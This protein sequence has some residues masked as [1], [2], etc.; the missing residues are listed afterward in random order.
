MATYGYIRTSRA[1]E[2][3]QPGSDPEA[4]R[5][6]LIGAGV[7]ARHI[8]A[9]V[10]VSGIAGVSSRNG[11]RALDSRLD[12][13][14]VLTVVA[15]DR[16]GR[17]YLDVMHAIHTLHSR[18]VRLRTLAEEEAT[19]AAFLDADPDSPEYFIGHTLAGFAAYAAGQERKAIS[20]RTIAGLEK[21]RDQ[22]KR[23][24][25]PPRLSGEQVD[26]VRQFRAA[27]VAISK[28]AREMGVPRSTVRNA[29]KNS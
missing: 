26:T 2:P 20:R 10:G 24:G 8:Y 27:G 28:I 5:R 1:Q 9:D 7:E 16:V 11:W 19:W 6:Q 23:L 29:L 14:D 21:A 13:G 12:K 3:G 18:G 17:S 22:G 15:L 25:R 4:Q